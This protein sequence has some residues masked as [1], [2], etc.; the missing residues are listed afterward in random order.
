MVTVT[1]S[2]E[3]LPTAIAGSR[4]VTSNGAFPALFQIALPFTWLFFWV[5]SLWDLSSPVRDRTLG[6]SNSESAES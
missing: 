6:H 5:C 1:R 2:L 4:F 3:A